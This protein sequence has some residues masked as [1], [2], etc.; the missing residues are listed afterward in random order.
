MATLSSALNYALSGLSVAAA[1]SSLASRNVS[2]ASD[3]NYTRKSA[4]IYSLAGGAPAV[5]NPTRSMDKQFLGKLLES[6]STAAASQVFIDAISRL[7]QSVGDPENDESLAAQLGKMQIELK[8]YES[9]PSSAALAASALEQA[10]VVASKLNAT[11]D[12]L[13]AVRSG[14]DASMA[15]AVDHVNSLLSQFKVVN[16]SIVRGSGTAAD[17]SESL[18]QRD[19][20]LKLLSEEIGIRTV[21]RSN[22]DVLIYTESG[23]VLFEGSPRSVTMQATEIFDPMSRGQAVMVDGIAVTGLSSP[24]PISTGKLAALARVRDETTVVLQKQLD[25][26]ASGLIQ[27]FAESDQSVVPTLPDAAGLFVDRDGGLPP[28]G[29]DPTGLASRIQ[30]NLLADPRA[31]GSPS[32]IRDG[33]FGGAQYTYNKLSSPSYQSRIGHLIESLDQ[34][35]P[36]DPTAGLG[37]SASL[38]AYSVQSAAWIEAQRKSAQTSS[39]G[40]LATKARASEALLRFTGVNID[41]EMA[42]LLDLEKS[43]Q[44]SSKVL[45]IVD[46]MLKTLLDAV[47]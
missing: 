31:G 12:E 23:A 17:L 40:A 30:I 1:Q 29:S 3:E 28:P 25:Q 9:N 34:P 20:I 22:N 24:M 27:S 44:A 45:S 36:F 41:Q 46:A 2:F 38:K 6:T 35:L 43:Y 33:G 21:S 26:I 7:S 13:I 37:A 11:S 32:L 15:D 18:D 42:A 19:S 39:A 10:R 47:G 8:I 4:E 16:D 14:A 5:A